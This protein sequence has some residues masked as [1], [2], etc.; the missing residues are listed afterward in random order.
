MYTIANSISFHSVDSCK[1][2]RIYFSIAVFA[3]VAVV[4]YC[5]TV[6]I[7][8]HELTAMPCV[9]VCHTFQSIIWFL[10]RKKRQMVYKR[11]AG[12]FRP[13]SW[14]CVHYAF[15]ENSCTWCCRDYFWVNFAVIAPFYLLISVTSVSIVVFHSYKIVN[16]SNRQSPFSLQCTFYLYALRTIDFR[17]YLL[18]C[19]RCHRKYMC[20]SNGTVSFE[21]NFCAA[22]TSDVCWFFLLCFKNIS[23]MSLH[24]YCQIHGDEW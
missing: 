7:V 22:L 15:G 23:K 3:V 18:S 20:H 10:G 5:T 4:V 6:N 24:S 8:C 13:T 2:R 19:V 1:Q 17:W 14:I 9:F 11:V 16:D 21:W 12:L